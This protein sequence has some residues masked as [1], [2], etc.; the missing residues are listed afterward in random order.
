MER[1]GMDSSNA[2]KAFS[3]MDTEELIGYIWYVSDGYYYSTVKELVKE[4][5]YRLNQRE[6][7]MKRAELA[8]QELS[9]IKHGY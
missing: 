5:E 8:E 4:I 3:E 1:G 6:T 9:E 2:A 7:C